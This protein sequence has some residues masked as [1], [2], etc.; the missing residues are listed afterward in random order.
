MKQFSNLIQW[1]AHEDESL[2]SLL[3]KLM[4]F[5]ETVDWM[6]QLLANKNE[7]LVLLVEWINVFKQNSSV[8]NE[9]QAQGAMVL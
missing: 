3:N 9:V 1:F 2:V 5:N 7:S 6:I 8:M 4:F